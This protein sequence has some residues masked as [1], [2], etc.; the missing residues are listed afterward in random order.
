MQQLPGYQQQ[1]QP[2]HEE[3]TLEQSK[4]GV[5]AYLT[6]H[7]LIWLDFILIFLE[8]AI[9]NFNMTG[10]TLSCICTATPLHSEFNVI[11]T[12]IVILV[13]RGQRLSTQ[14]HA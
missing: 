9:L 8:S 7:Q 3:K 4:L 1:P 2:F 6:L 11:D 12:S 13:L 5:E 10:G 14:M